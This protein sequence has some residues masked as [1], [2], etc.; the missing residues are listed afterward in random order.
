MRLD[1]DLEALIEA[2]RKGDDSARSALVAAVYPELKKIAKT[3]M[4]N[5]RRPDH[6]LGQQTGSGLAG[7]FVLRFLAKQWEPR[8]ALIH[9]AGRMKQ[10]LW[11]HA[12]AHLAQKRGGGKR[13]DIDFE[14]VVS[15]LVASNKEDAGSIE[16]ATLF[17]QVRD[18]FDA[19]E[20]VEEELGEE[21]GKEARLAFE[22]VYFAGLTFEET[23]AVLCIDR[24][25]CGRRVK[26]VERLLREKLLGP[27]SSTSA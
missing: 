12:R 4:S 8:E 3:L 6:T 16:R 27:S 26:L 10:I 15:D 14:L 5:E 13:A 1:A 11:D 20:E 25:T 2:T 22:L 7:E 23:E 21:K 9:A 18:A 19:L 17:R 24:V